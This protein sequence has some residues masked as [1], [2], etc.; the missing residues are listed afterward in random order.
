ML[1][2]F[3]NDSIGP[4]ILAVLAWLLNTTVLNDKSRK[5][6]L[7]HKRLLT[8]SAVLTTGDLSTSGS[9]STSL[10]VAYTNYNKYVDK[11][12]M[13]SSLIIR[14]AIPCYQLASF[15]VQQKNLISK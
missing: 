11:A 4:H 14:I 7:K 10:V 8:F 6:I 13:L 9:S 15:P 2:N 3:N 12:C 5:S 1:M